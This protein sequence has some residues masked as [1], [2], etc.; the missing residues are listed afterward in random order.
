MKDAEWTRK[1]TNDEHG[2]LQNKNICKMVN[3]IRSWN[4]QQ[5]QQQQNNA[6]RVTWI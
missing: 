2:A 3:E 5:Q 1:Q 6:T 4:A